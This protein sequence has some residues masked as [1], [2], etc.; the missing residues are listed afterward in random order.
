[1]ILLDF[2]ELGQ[3]VSSDN[4]I[5]VQTKLNVQTSRTSAE[6]KTA[7]LLQLSIIRPHTS[8]STVVHVARPGWT[9]LPHPPYSLDLV[10]SDF[11]FFRPMK[12]G[13]PALY[14]PNNITIAAVKQRVTSTGAE[15]YERGMQ[16]LVHGWQKCISNGGVCGK[17][18]ENLLYP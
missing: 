5:T 4:D 10:P 18:A 2:L 15:F 12:G 6:K 13:L 7:F 1:M 8:L 17:I 16:D 3:T 11:H 9:V 14:F